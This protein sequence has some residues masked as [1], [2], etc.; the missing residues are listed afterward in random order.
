MAPE[1]DRADLEIAGLDLLARYDEP[2]RRYHDRRHLSEVL[3][4]VALL[5]ED[6]H[7]FSAVMLAAWWHDAVYQPG[8][9]D[10]EEASAILASATLT[11]WGADPDRALHVGDLVRMTGTHT[12]APYN[13]DALVLSDAD[14]AILGSPPTR[15]AVYAADIRSEHPDVSDDQFRSGRSQVLRTLLARDQIYRTPSAYERWEGD[16]RANM[17]AELD[18]LGG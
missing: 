18:H 16:A 14:L 4:A 13:A 10:N 6:A 3:A 8:A 5:A 11:A 7:D 12:P 1:V 2:H 17:Q 9:G 15:Y